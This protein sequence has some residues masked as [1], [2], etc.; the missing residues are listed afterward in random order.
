MN[1]VWL[2]LFVGQRLAILA[3]L[4]WGLKHADSQGTGLLMATAFAF[5]V[6]DTFRVLVEWRRRA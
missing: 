5:C 1:C 6:V 2:A 4:A 3:L